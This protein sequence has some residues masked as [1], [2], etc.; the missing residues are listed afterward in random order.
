M[1]LPLI[2]ENGGSS[3]VQDL[4]GMPLFGSLARSLLAHCS[5]PLQALQPRISGKTWIQSYLSTPQMRC[6]FHYIDEKGK[7]QD[8]NGNDLQTLK[9]P[10]PLYFSFS[11]QC[12]IVRKS[13]FELL[14]DVEEIRQER[15]KAKANRTKYVGLG[16]DGF[17]FA[18]VTAVWRDSLGS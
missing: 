6:S 3:V 2:Y 18:S 12:G 1:Y 11:R 4:Q 15:K 5:L 7:D 10:P 17:S 14:A 13:S 8:I 16:H 9:R